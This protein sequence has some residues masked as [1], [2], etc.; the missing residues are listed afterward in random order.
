[1]KNEGR[2]KVVER[3]ETKGRQR[4]MAVER[5]RLRDYVDRRQEI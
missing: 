2:L 1:M 3:P 5:E 4:I